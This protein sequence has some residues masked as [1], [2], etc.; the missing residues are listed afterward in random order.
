MPDEDH[1]MQKTRTPIEG[2]PGESV[3]D[4]ALPPAPGAEP[5]AVGR[6][7]APRPRPIAAE[8]PRTRDEA[9]EAIARTRDKI[10]GTLD[11]IEQRLREKKEEL[12]E[13]TDISARLRELVSGREIPALMVALGAGFLLALLLGRGRGSGGDVV[14]SQEELEALRGWQK[15]RKRVLSALE[16]SARALEELQD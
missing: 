11:E 3:P 16:R 12:K 13:R 15:D 6:P 5:A 4:A 1:V 14:L 2:S 9:R 8:E 7:A 10:S